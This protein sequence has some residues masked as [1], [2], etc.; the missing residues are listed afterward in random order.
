MP[1]A[2][3]KQNKNRAV[4]HLKPKNNT[5]RVQIKEK[6]LRH[7]KDKDPTQS[8]MQL[9]ITNKTDMNTANDTNIS[10]AHLELLARPLH[11]PPAPPSLENKVNTQA[12]DGFFYTNML[13]DESINTV[14]NENSVSSP[15]SPTPNENGIWGQRPKLDLNVLTPK[16]MALITVKAFGREDISDYLLEVY[17]L[18]LLEGLVL[19]LE[20]R[21][22]FLLTACVKVYVILRFAMFYPKNVTPIANGK[23]LNHVSLLCTSKYCPV[24]LFYLYIW[25]QS[26][27]QFPTYLKEVVFHGL[28]TTV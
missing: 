11:N 14:S 8:D 3:T 6:S 7:D 20:S 16:D 25:V 28:E 19:S 22:T 27:D 9:S 12:I 10:A 2:Y 23:A 26:Y 24:L 1:P 21:V 15:S 4:L 13:E 18:A 5:K 17:L